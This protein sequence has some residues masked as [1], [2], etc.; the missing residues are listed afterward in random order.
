MIRYS[1]HLCKSAQS[2]YICGRILIFR[3]P[4]KFPTIVFFSSENISTFAV[5][6]SQTHITAITEPSETPVFVERENAANT[7]KNSDSCA[8]I[9]PYSTNFSPCN[10]NFSPCSTNFSPCSINFVA[11]VSVTEAKV[12]VTEAK[13]GVTE[14]KVGVTEAKVGVTDAKVGV[15]EEKVFNINP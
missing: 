13:V 11:K 14:A 7:Y 1:H 12:G 5:M 2:Q 9:S 4:L 10:T 15:T 6:L 3:T 8:D